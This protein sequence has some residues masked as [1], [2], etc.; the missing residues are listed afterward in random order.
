[1]RL[2]ARSPAG[3]SSSHILK[4]QLVQSCI[5]WPR[6][7]GVVSVEL[8]A[9]SEWMCSPQEHLRSSLRPP[10]DKAP[11]RQATPML[12]I[13][14]CLLLARTSCIFWPLA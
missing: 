13:M 6:A 7:C 4:L 12:Q 1:M 3:P 2:P 8:D 11:L 14:Q 5:C 9:S 10:F